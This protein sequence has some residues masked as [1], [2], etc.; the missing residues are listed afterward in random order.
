MIL[1]VHRHERRQAFILFCTVV[2]TTGFIGD[3]FLGRAHAQE[4][5]VSTARGKSATRTRTISGYL[6][7]TKKKRSITFEVVDGQAVYQGDII[8]GKAEKI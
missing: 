3:L 8:L 7:G 4:E 1:R 2:L 5:A 6:P